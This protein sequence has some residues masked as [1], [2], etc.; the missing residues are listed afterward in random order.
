[1]VPQ[2]SERFLYKNSGIS[3]ANSSRGIVLRLLGGNFIL[4]IQSSFLLSVI[5]FP[6]SDANGNFKV[7]GLLNEEGRMA[8]LS[9]SFKSLREVE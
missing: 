2:I 6:L 4:R 3:L 8:G 1:M 7:L 9:L 5:H